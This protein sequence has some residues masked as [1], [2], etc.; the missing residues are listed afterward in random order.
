MTGAYWADDSEVVPVNDIL[1]ADA[2]S[3]YCV[4]MDGTAACCEWGDVPSPDGVRGCLAREARS[5]LSN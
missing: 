1:P 3:H 5:G 4:L 2:L